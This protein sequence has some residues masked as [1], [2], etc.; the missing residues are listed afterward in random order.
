[1]WHGIGVFAP[2]QLLN[3]YATMRRAC[4]KDSL[5]KDLKKE[6]GVTT[7]TPLSFNLVPSNMWVHPT[8]RNIDASIGCVAN[9]NDLGKMGMRL[10]YLSNS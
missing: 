10:E 3:S 6:Y 9:L 1:M 8:H 2:P 7:N 5:I 4:A